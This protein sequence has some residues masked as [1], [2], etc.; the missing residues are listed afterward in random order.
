MRAVLVSLSPFA[1]TTAGFF[2][3]KARLADYKVAYESD[4]MRQSNLTDTLLSAQDTPLEES[5]V[6]MAAKC[7]PILA[8]MLFVALQ[9]FGPYRLTKDKEFNRYSIY[10]LLNMHVFCNSSYCF[11]GSVILNYFQI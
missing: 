1:L 5:T 7:A 11:I 6:Y 10:I 8:L 2:G 9:A 4:A 3:Y